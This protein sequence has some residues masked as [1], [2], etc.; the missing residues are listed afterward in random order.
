M[1]QTVLNIITKATI[2]V[3]A[4]LTNKN[5]QKGVFAIPAT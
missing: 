3:A 5:N 2:D 4:I 1:T